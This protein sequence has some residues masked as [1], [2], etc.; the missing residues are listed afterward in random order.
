M[1]IGWAYILSL[2]CASKFIMEAK[3]DERF[4]ENSRFILEPKNDG[5]HRWTH[6]LPEPFLQLS[7]C[8]ETTPGRRSRRRSRFDE[9]PEEEAAEDEA[10]EE[11]HGMEHGSQNSSMSGWWFET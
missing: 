9:K 2:L 6:P 11:P 1:E 7:T 5:K 8:R 10:V 4:D 3:N